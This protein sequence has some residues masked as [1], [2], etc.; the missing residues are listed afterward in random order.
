MHEEIH[1]GEMRVLIAAFEQGRRDGLPARRFLLYIMPGLTR[2][3]ATST[4]NHV[5]K[6]EAR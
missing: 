2:Q 5:W 4:G 1:G 3:H 6:V